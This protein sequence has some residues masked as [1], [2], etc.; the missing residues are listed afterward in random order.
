ARCIDGNLAGCGEAIQRAEAL[1][2]AGYGERHPEYGLLLTYRTWLMRV[3]GS[4]RHEL[5]ALTRKS[6]SLLR[7]HYPLCHEKVANMQISLAQRLVNH[8]ETLP[9]GQR[10]NAIDEA[11]GL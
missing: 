10:G 5:L 3:E 2:L 4:P 7:Q 6:L 1:I 9:E 8:L 11:M